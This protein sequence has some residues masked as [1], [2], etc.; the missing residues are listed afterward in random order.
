MLRPLRNEFLFVFLNET[1]NGVFVPKNK[2]RIIIAAHKQNDLRGQGDYARW[3]KVVAIGRDVK[4]FKTGDIVLI[5]K[6]KWT[7]GFEY[8]GV[9]IWRSDEDKVL[10]LGDDESVAYDYNYS[11]DQYV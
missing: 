1:A 8:D 10:A 4:D 11:Y 5:D 3:A 2:G 6:L 7:K 9:M